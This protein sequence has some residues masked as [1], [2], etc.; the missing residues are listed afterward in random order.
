MMMQRQDIFEA[1]DKVRPDDDTIERMLENVRAMAKEENLTKRE[2]KESAGRKGKKRKNNRVLYWAAAAAIVMIVPITV[3]AVHLLGLWDLGIGKQK[4]EVPVKTELGED[5]LTPEGTVK[6]EEQEVDMISLQGVTGSPEYMACMEWQ[7][8]L[9]EYDTDDQ[10]LAKVGNA[11]TG[12]EEEYGEYL[13]YSQEMAD[14]IDEICEKYQLIK[15]NG[16]AEFG[17]Y[18]DFCSK[19]GSGDICGT[20]ENVFIAY[21]GGYY[22]ADG[23]FLFEGTA[24]ITGEGGCMTSFQFCRNMKGTFNGAALNVGNMEEYKQWEY[25]TKRGEK[26]LLANSSHKALIIVEKEKSFSVVN[27]LGNILGDSFDVSDEALE[28][29]ADGFDFSAL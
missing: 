22:Y 27:M 23:T 18:E 12:F 2:K 28:K 21:E 17:D 3:G 13:C 6:L 29:L 24:A 26:V 14:K 9:E 20:S 5:L 4:V 10:V 16:F 19:T 15:L 1:Y 11:P 25:E 8:F 7:K